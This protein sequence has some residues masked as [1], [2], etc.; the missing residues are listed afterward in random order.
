MISSDRAA[1]R[2]YFAGL[3]KTALEGS[4]KPCAAVYDH[5]TA[6]WG[7]LSPVLVITE[8]G[9]EWT[10][11][12]HGSGFMPRAHYL[13]V[14]AFAV[15]ATADGKIGED[16]SESMLSPIQS[17]LAEVLSDNRNSA[18]WSSISYEARSTVDPVKIKGREYRHEVVVLRFS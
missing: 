15:Y 2:V 14:H 13:A 6:D 10:Q 11:L 16:D 1:L 17:E 9:T 12:T 7:T 5:Q 4:G 3:C 8:A 18:Y